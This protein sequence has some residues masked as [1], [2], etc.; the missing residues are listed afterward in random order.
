V[1]GIYTMLN[2]KTTLLRDD[3]RAAIIAIARI[4]VGKAIIASM[5]R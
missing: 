4:R 3:P 2:A 1:L 5:T